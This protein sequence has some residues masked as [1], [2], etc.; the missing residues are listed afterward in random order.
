MAEREQ[1][2]QQLDPVGGYSTRPVTVLM[3][4]GIFVYAVIVTL[5]GWNVVTEPAL[6]VASLVAC[7]ASVLGTVYWSSP[8]RAPFSRLGFITTVSLGS[9][10]MV[11]SAVS[12]WGG[13]STLGWGPI[14]IGLILLQLGPYRPSRDLLGATL[15]IS[16]VGGFFAILRPGINNL[17]KPQLVTIVESVLPLIALGLASRAYATALGKTLDAGAPGLAIA[18]NAATAELRA[19]ITRSVQHDRVTIL[20][21]TVVPFL[22]DV[23]ERN[24]VTAEDRD[25]ASVIANSIRTLMVAD[26]DRS[27]LDTVID[28]AGQGSGNSSVPGSEVVQDDDHV[29]SSM[30]PKQRAML[31]ALL[32]ALFAHPGF[33]ADGFGILLLRNGDT[34]AF[35]LT[36]KLDH[37]ES[38]PRSGL[39]VYFAVLRI[40]FADLQLTFEPPTLTLRFSYDHK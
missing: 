26:V 25:R 7:A 37:E 14:V 20:N 35:T 18:E 5:R 29:A 31:R 19:D 16:I 21:R 38:L 13:K 34:C 15:L 4:L 11:L 24:A 40:V 32:V 9:L 36:A 6:A 33:D 39:G 8:L 12:T 28:Q 2:Y 30:S 23:L 1:S 27:W 3:S 17:D 10:A 22:T